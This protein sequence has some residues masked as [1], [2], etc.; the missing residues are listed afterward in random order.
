[1]EISRAPVHV[2]GPSLAPPENPS[3][4]NLKKHVFVS[5]NAETTIF[6]RSRAFRVKR[7]W[8]QNRV[9]HVLDHPWS[10]TEHEPF[11]SRPPRSFPKPTLEGRGAPEILP[12]EPGASKGQIKFAKSACSKPWKYVYLAPKD[13]KKTLSDHFSTLRIAP[14]DPQSGAPNP[15]GRLG[16]PKKLPRN[17][18]DSPGSPSGPPRDPIEHL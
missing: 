13:L 18:Q 9:F 1:M 15:Q 5:K 12:R 2:S 6:I 3:E 8:L 16:T 7:Q 11:F 4:P 14:R 17:A 10:P